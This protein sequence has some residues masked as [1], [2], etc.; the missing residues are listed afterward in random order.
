M[1]RERKV[2]GLME[3]FYIIK[4]RLNEAMKIRGINLSE[5]ADL[6]GLNKSSVSRYLN[7]KMVPRTSQ[8]GKMAAALDVSPTWILGYNVTMSGDEITEIDT[9]KLSDRNREKL[10]VYYQ[11]LLDSQEEVK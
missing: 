7:G 2:G 4:D 6:S 11:A 9:S 3:N 5:L 10:F 8:I 1:G